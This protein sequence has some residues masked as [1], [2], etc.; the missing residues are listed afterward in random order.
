[1]TVHRFRLA[2][3]RCRRQSAR[4]ARANQGFT[5]IEVLVALAIGAALIGVLTGMLVLGVR[6]YTDTRDALELSVRKQVASGRFMTDVMSAEQLR[7]PGDAQ[8]AVDGHLHGFS[9]N[10]GPDGD[11]E[12]VVHADWGFANGVLTRRVCGDINAGPDVLLT[13]LTSATIDCGLVQTCWLEWS[14]GMVPPDGFAAT[15][16][17]DDD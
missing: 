12:F 4:L 16:R 9:W 3:S 8:C 11:D 17:V 7:G 13:N 14:P 1:M 15:R 6:T 2:R 5:L 10:Y